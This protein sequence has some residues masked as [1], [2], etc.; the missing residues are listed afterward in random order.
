[1]EMTIVDAVKARHTVR[2]F[3]K[4]PLAAVD[5]V[6]M[7]SKIAEIN[8]NHNLQIRLLADVNVPVN[9]TMKLF[10]TKGL[11]NYIILSGPN[12]PSVK[13][14]LGYVG[15][16]IMLYAQTIGLNTWWVGGSYDRRQVWR[17]ALGHVVA[18]IIVFGYGQNQ[19]RPHRTRCPH[20]VSSY[21]GK[22]PTWFEEGVKLALLAPTPDNKQDFLITGR[23]N[24]VKFYCDDGRWGDTVK[25]IIRYYFET[26][27][28]Q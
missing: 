22:M 21:V 3:R 6:K 7:N 24:D 1:M 5:I 15:A 17:L 25:G 16:E 14:K 4:E 27:A 2:R 26:G 28:F 18:G 9:W 12:T 10:K 13:E 11:R 19:G 8:R 20:E 23:G